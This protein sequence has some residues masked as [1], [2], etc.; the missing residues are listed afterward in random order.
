MD[1]WMDGWMAILMNKRLDKN[2]RLEGR[3]IDKGMDR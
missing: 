1:G 3:W 2:G